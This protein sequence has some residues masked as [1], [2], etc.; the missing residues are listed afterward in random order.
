M[1]RRSENL[2]GT[3]Q[4]MPSGANTSDAFAL[5]NN[6]DTSAT[7]R[8]MITIEITGVLLD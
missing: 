1:L 3:K 4:E 8:K 7:E 2:N 6:Q 5:S